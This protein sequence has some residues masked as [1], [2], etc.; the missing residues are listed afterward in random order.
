M[1][2]SSNENSFDRDRLAEP[3]DEKLVA[4]SPSI[5]LADSATIEFAM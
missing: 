2:P 1:E 4:K 3:I 5:D